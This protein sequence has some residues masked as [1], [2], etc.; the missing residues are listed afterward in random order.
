V[1]GFLWQI[2]VWLSDLGAWIAEQLESTVKRIVGL[3]AIVVL[4]AL[5]G[6]WISFGQ[7]VNF[8]VQTFGL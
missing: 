5:L 8:I 1:G 2:P 6:G 7:I 4:V 3:V